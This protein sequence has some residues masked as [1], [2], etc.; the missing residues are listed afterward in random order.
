MTLIKDM[1]LI[2]PLGALK[3][4]LIIDLYNCG[5]E[6]NSRLINSEYTTPATR[7]FSS[8]I[9]GNMKNNKTKN[10]MKVAQNMLF[11]V[12]SVVFSN[13]RNLF[14]MKLKANKV[15]KCLINMIIARIK[16]IISTAPIL[17]I[18]D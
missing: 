7:K 10:T 15:G 13:F 11:I 12:L 5:R 18:I 3:T 2:Q 6:V 9:T 17:E 4:S 8:P 16:P 14:F 1:I